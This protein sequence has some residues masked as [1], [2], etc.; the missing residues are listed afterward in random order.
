MR[1]STMTAV[2]NP[3]ADVTPAELR[4]LSR[5][6]GFMVPASAE[7]GVPGDDDEAIFVDIVRSLGRDK[8]DVREALAML[9]EIAG[10]DFAGL[11]AVTQKDGELTL[12]A[13]DAS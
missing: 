12:I 6:A 3:S 2:E 1:R 11:E 10:G 13:C 5:L 9:R 8:D 4:D 7:Y